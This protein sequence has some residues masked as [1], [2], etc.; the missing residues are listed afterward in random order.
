MITFRARSLLLL[1]IA[2][3][4]SSASMR[5]C[6]PLLPEFVQA[7]GVTEGSASWVI[8]AFSIA[9]GSLQILYGPAGDRHGKYRVVAIVTTV[10]AVATLA[11]A[12]APTFTWLVIARTAV[13]ASAA[14]I[15]PMSMAWIGDSVPYERRQTTLARLLTGQILGV[16]AGQI[17]G[18]FFADT[19]GWRWCF[20]VLAAVFCTAAALLWRQL[21]GAPPVPLP[22]PVHRRTPLAGALAVLKSKRAQC[23]LAIVFLEGMAVYG[24]F[25]FVPSYL[26]T[27]FHTPLTAAG[28]IAGTYGLGGLLY[29][30]AVTRLL[31]RI[32]ERGFALA[33]GVILGIGFLAYA[34]A[35][36]WA[37]ALPAGALTGLGFY[38]LHNTLQTHATQ[39]LPERRGTAV[40]IFVSAF[41]LGQS[42][43]TAITG[44]LIGVTGFTAPF[45]AAALILPCA[46]LWLAAI[47]S[48]RTSSPAPRPDHHDRNGQ[49]KQVPA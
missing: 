31:K 28:L 1:A 34:T 39:M 4:A 23:I 16:I 30:L 48:P 3:F 2:A 14:A 21:V 6:D 41:F 35:P 47:S 15:I 8:S 49:S 27:Q 19:F 12:L 13:G 18:G 22:D 11:A 33:G 44:P 40:S 17:L 38:M 42:A 10:C 9:Y 43:G 37:W 32:G 5:I 24:P 20:A 29:S 46:G 36:G 26:H 7:F 25:A 45:V